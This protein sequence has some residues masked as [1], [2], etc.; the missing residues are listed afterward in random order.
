MTLK[1]FIQM[2]CILNLLS[3]MAKSNGTRMDCK[4]QD[5]GMKYIICFLEKR[6]KVRED[7]LLLIAISGNIIIYFFTFAFLL[8]NLSLIPCNLQR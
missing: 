5:S 2:W 1:S 3:D 4:S 6:M 7:I 8:I